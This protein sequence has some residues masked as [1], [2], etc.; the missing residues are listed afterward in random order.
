M[1][2]A[3]IKPRLPSLPMKSCFRSYLQNV[4]RNHTAAVHNEV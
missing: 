4:C 1:A 2:T 3:V